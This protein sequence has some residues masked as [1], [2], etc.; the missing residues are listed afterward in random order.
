MAKSDHSVTICSLIYSLAKSKM[1]K[2]KKSTAGLWRRFK[3]QK[4]NDTV[5]F[6]HDDINFDIT[7]DGH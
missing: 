1:S 2:V 7:Y 5:K 6:T 3:K 4:K